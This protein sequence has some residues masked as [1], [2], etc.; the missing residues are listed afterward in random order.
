MSPLDLMEVSQ[1]WIS[2]NIN[3]ESPGPGE[4]KVENGLHGEAS[5]SLSKRRDVESY[6][7]ICLE[8]SFDSSL[9]PPQA[10]YGGNGKTVSFGGS[11]DAVRKMFTVTIASAQVPVLPTDVSV[12]KPIGKLVHTTLSKTSSNR[13]TP[14]E[15]ASSEPETDQS[16]ML[17]KPPDVGT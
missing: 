1:K 16:M 12:E 7:P 14:E 15:D 6:T 5:I 13:F 17:S 10:L 11:V 3:L 8:D 9:F 4:T 2:Q